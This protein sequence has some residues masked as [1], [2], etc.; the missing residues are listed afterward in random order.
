MRGR[1]PS[2]RWHI[3]HWSITRRPT[4]AWLWQQLIETTA[5]A[6]PPRFLIRDRD[7]C[8]GGDFDA[9]TAGIG[10]APS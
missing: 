2:Q 8:Y 9:R 5:W 6:R 4:A 10:I 3:E 1:P 7:R